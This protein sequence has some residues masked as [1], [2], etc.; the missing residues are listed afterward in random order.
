M[1]G[2]CVGVIIIR[3]LEDFL[4]LSMLVEPSAIQL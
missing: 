4:V 3:F 2:R 1:R